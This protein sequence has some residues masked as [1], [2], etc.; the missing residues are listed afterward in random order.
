MFSGSN[1]CGPWAIANF[2]QVVFGLPKYVI[3]SV[4]RPYFVQLLLGAL[5]EE[6]QVGFPGDTP[7]V[8]IL[9]EAGPPRV[10]RMPGF[11]PTV[12]EKVYIKIV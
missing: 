8:T 1:D 9:I 12:L 10:N 3:P 4:V 2:V 11:V 5:V 6:P 7:P